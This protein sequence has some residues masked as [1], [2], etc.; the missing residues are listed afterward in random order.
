MIAN[1]VVGSA[2]AFKINLPRRDR[3]PRTKR[4]PV[5]FRNVSPLLEDV[6]LAVGRRMVSRSV[7]LSA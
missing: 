3:D 4:Y 7:L 2:F 5:T 1:S 6:R